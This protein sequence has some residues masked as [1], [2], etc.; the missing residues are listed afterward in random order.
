MKFEIPSE[1]L[2]KLLSFG[3]ELLSL[4]RVNVKSLASWVGSL[5]ACR[6]AIGPIVSILCRSLYDDIKNA[7]T[8]HSKITL[9][10]QARV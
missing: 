7:K 5:Q 10:S 2:E 1:K 4:R 3:R 8:W 6:L 9:S